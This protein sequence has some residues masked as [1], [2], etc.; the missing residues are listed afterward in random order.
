MARKLLTG[1]VW[2]S[3]ILLLA[4][5]VRARLG[6]PPIDFMQFYFGGRLAAAGRVGEIYRPRSYDSLVAEMRAQGET[7]SSIRG[8]YCFRRPAFAAFLYVPLS[9]L[10]YRTAALAWLGTNLAMIGLL[11]WKLP[12]WFPF[13]DHFD[14]N[15]TGALLLMFTPFLATLA[16]GQ[17]AVLLTLLAAL[18][19]YAAL[20]GRD[21]EAG[22]A[23]A[24]CFFK[25]HLVFLLPLVA[26]ASRRF[27]LLAWF[28]GAGLILALVTFAAVG[29]DGTRQWIDLVGISADFMPESMANARALGLQFGLL[30]GIAAGL[31]VTLCVASI[32][33]R[34]TMRERFSAAILASLL[35]SPHTY[36][37]DLSLTV[38]TA[39]LAGSPVWR[40]LLLVPWL[41]FYSRPDLVP[42]ILLAVVYLGALAV[43]VI[44][45]GGR[46][47]DDPAMVSPR[48]QVLGPE[49]RT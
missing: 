1:V 10:P 31:F 33:I 7:I 9:W 17:D 26:V 40:Y 5:V 8:G 25:P 6:G 30:A 47:S 23:L 4:T 2:L 22:I 28:A 12:L 32:L 13:E 44:R 3:P 20:Q 43:E 16:Q 48:R 18:G 49:T 35:L 34:G 45:R 29:L 42:V 14:R 21:V 36:K 46:N 11:V 41:M 19:I 38:V 15:L 37:Y 27:K 24:A 39:L